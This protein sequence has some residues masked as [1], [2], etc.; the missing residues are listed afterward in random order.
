[1]ALHTKSLQIKNKM[2]LSVYLMLTLMYITA[3]ALNFIPLNEQFF[4]CSCIFLI[5]YPLLK[6][7]KV[8]ERFIQIYIILIMNVLILLLISKTFYIFSLYSLIFYLIL[9]GMYFSTRLLIGS[10]FV[11]TVEIFIL[12]F[13]HYLDDFHSNVEYLVFWVLGSAIFFISFIILIF[14]RINWLRKEKHMREQRQKNLSKN[15]YLQ[16]FFEYSNDAIAVF[17]T[18]N[19]IMEVNP[20]FEKL[21]GW[22]RE[23]CVGNFLPLVPPHYEKEAHNRFKRVLAGESIASETEEMKKD[24]T[25]FKSQTSLSPILDRKGNVRAISIVSRDISINKENERLHMQSEKL[26]LAGEIAAG[27]AHEIRNPMTVISGFAQMMQQDENSPYKDYMNIVQDEI[28]RIDLI[29]SEFLV[30]SKP[31]IKEKDW[32]DLRSII[33]EIATFYELEFKQKNIVFTY[34]SNCEKAVMYGN[35]NQL[36]QVFINLIKNSIEAITNEGTIHIELK[37]Q[38]TGYLISLK[39]SGCG[40]PE[41]IVE[42]IFEPFYTTKIKGTGLG[43]MII[44]KIVRDHEGSIKVFSKENVGTDIH[45]QFTTHYDE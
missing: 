37:E 7:S 25:I 30:L 13:I 29:I 12:T 36:K 10:A 17:D 4:I 21:Y 31:Q 15:A 16:L 43:M 18:N 8:P 41:E 42:H 39:D 35:K 20:A 28:E 1:M 40:I 38:S 24:G 5:A 3:V 9:I 11:V 19:T 44:H 26:R 23:E 22:T 14:M 6:I 45:I 33:Q 34:D 2:I 27:V 32:I